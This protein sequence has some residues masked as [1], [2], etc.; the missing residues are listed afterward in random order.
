MTNV[1]IVDDERLVQELFTHYINSAADRYALA[2]TT[3]DAANAEMICQSKQV[4]LILMDICT[5]N[6][7]S[8][9]AAAEKVKRRFPQ[10]KIIIVTSAPEFR[11]IEKAHAAGADSFW[12]KDVGLTELL[13]VMDRTMRGESIYPDKTP[14]V[15]I[16]LTTSYEFTP[17][18]LE[19]LIYLS[20]GSSS[21]AITEKMSISADTVNDHI[22]H[23][24]EKTG[25]TSKTQLAVLASRSKLVLPEY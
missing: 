25:C 18:E 9:L 5:A 16:G 13:D 8:G 12:Y 21:K 4:D 20:S 22:K 14:E 2:E 1:L 11:F 10:T 15:T 7:S 6:D 23:L 19:V 24:K 17:K 3:S